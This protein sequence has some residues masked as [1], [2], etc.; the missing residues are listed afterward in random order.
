MSY[1]MHLSHNMLISWNMMLIHFSTCSTLSTLSFRFLPTLPPPAS[2]ITFVIR[3]CHQTALYHHTLSVVPAPTARENEFSRAVGAVP[4]AH[5]SLITE[6][7]HLYQETR[8]FPIEP[9]LNFLH[10][11]D[12]RAIPLTAAQEWRDPKASY[13]SFCPRQSS[14]K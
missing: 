2:S 9:T 10:F 12:T 13:I 11:M 14:E 7:R 8:L 4:P 6:G 3:S 1:F 5:K